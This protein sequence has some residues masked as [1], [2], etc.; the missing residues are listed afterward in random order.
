MKIK[1]SK[2]GTKI[3]MGE[4]FFPGL[5]GYAMEENNTIFIPVVSARKKGNGDFSKLL[6]ELDECGKKV[7]FSATFN[8][9]IIII[10]LAHGY[11]PESF[12]TQFPDGYQEDAPCMVKYPK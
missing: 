12:T 6:K 1:F 11:K 10:L 7:C 2:E 4:E 9:K 5:D 3:K 8:P